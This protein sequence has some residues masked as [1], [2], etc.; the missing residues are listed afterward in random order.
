VLPSRRRTAWS[1]FILCELLTI[2]DLN[3]ISLKEHSVFRPRGTVSTIFAIASQSSERFEHRVRS[4]ME[5]GAHCALLEAP[6][7]SLPQFI[8]HE[9]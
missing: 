6:N 5:W 4:L 2:V 3:L 7:L 8:R 9:N 1:V